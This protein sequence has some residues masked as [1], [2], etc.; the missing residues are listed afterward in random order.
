MTVELTQENFTST[1][2]CGIVVLDWW[3]P[4]CGPCRAFAPVFAAAAA[5]HPDMVFA[6]V[7]TEEQPGLAAAFR[8]RAIPTIMIFRDGI[9]MFAEPGMPSAAGLDELLGK[10]AAVDMDELRKRIRA[11][12][13]REAAKAG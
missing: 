4:W 1:I 13:A 11:A 3:A 9:L 2:E 5:R 6:K 8:I 10:V 12:E 7:N